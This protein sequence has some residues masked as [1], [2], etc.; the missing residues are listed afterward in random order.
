MKAI[1]KSS[2]TSREV[3]RTAFLCLHDQMTEGYE[4]NLPVI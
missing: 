2:S 1:I 4:E 3:K